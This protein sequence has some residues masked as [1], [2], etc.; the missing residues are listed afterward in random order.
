LAQQLKERGWSDPDAG[1]EPALVVVN[2][3][4]VTGKAAMQSRQAVRRACREFPGA[5]VVATGC[6]AQVAPED[7]RKIDGVDTVCGNVEKGRIEALIDGA[8]SAA[9][10]DVSRLRRFSPIRAPLLTDRTR[11]VLKIQDG[12]DA[13]CTYCIVPHARGRSRSMPVEDVLSHIR[14]LEAAGFCEV[15]LSGIH[16]GA[17]GADREPQTSLHAL[18]VRIENETRIPRV[19]LSSIEPGELTPEIRA[20]AAAS[21]RIC[22]HFHVPLQSG[23]DVILKK[24]GR[25]YSAAEFEALVVDLRRRMPDAAIGADILVGFPGETEASFEQTCRLVKQLPITY[26]HV[27]PFSARPGTPAF[28]F[29]G[30][31]AAGEIQDRC[32]RLRTIGDEKR[33]GFMDRFLN[34]EVSALVEGRRDSKSGFLKAT[35]ANYISVL[36]DGPKTLQNRIVSCRIERRID[37]KSVCGFQVGSASA[38]GCSLSR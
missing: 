21:A 23:D 17:Y 16:L 3:C 32:R 18:L 36:L 8:E 4:A 24:M 26:L 1:A 9:V 13:F 11:P 30:K 12:C 7:L 6:Y 25:P 27:F 22:P 15:V 10:S 19:R 37:G 20:H 33:V 34:R 14:S 29:P 28:H 38:A 31:V 35:T 2:T 5:R